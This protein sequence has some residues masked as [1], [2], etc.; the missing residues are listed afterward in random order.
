M[1]DNIDFSKIYSFSKLDL[2]DK[3]KKQYYFNY[4]DPEVAPRKKEFIKPRDYK[5]KGSAVHNAITLFYHLPLEKRSFKKLR[6]FLFDAWFAENAPVKAPPLGEAGGFKDIEH[7]RETYRQ[8][9]ELLKN[10]F[11]LRD[12]NPPVFYLPTKN[13]RY[14]FDDYKAMIKP[15]EGNWSISGKFDRIDKME[16]GGLRVIDFKTGKNS[17]NTSQLEFYALLA[18]MNFPEKV[19][20]VSFYYLDNKK[21]LNFDFSKIDRD[22]IKKGIVEKISAIE[23]THKDDFHTH[24]NA[25]CNHCDFKVI[26]P[27][28]GNS[29][30]SIDNIGNNMV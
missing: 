7:E 12:F 24:Q 5:T 14:S 15:I 30:A 10:F 28:F 17:K 19:K 8:S 4:L 11:E 13:I 22:K 16:D 9:L 2:F 21:I 1:K 18:E 23:N 20:I 25:L 26:C 3:C 27:A 6:D 29:I